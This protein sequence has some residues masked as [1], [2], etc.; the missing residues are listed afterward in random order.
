MINTMSLLLVY[1]LVGELLVRL[2]SLTLPGPVLGMAL[3]FLTLLVRGKVSQELRSW[4]SSLLQHLSLLFVPAG[5]GVV[6]HLQRVADEWL[7]IVAA[8]VISTFIGL[9]V[10]ALIICAMTRQPAGEKS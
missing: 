8:T 5:V 1:Q 3:L 4:T 10:T 6:V 7:P 2:F 9:G